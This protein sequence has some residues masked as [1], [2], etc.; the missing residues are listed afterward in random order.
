[1]RARCGA[2]LA[3]AAALAARDDAATGG[4]G[5]SLSSG[6]SLRLRGASRTGSMRAFALSA[7]GLMDG[8]GRRAIGCGGSSCVA[9]TCGSAFTGAG[10]GAAAYASGA[11]ASAVSGISTA[12]GGGSTASGRWQGWPKH[13]GSAAAGVAI[14]A[15]DAARMKKVT[16]R[17]M[18]FPVYR[19]LAASWVCL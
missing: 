11:V 19:R 15:A 7:T 2:W 8:N 4:N 9:V 12:A 16:R 5:A 17:D 14:S 1:M 18:M 10:L 6:A 13:S 3:G